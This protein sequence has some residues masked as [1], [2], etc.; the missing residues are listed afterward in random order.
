MI[1]V[2]VGDDYGINLEN[3]S[4]KEEPWKRIALSSVYYRYAIGFL[5]PQL[6]I[7]DRR[8]GSTLYGARSLNIGLRCPLERSQEKIV[9][10]GAA[11]VHLSK[12]SYRPA[13][14]F[15]KWRPMDSSSINSSGYRIAKSGFQV[16]T[17]ASTTGISPPS[18]TPSIRTNVRHGFRSGAICP[19]SSLSD[20]FNPS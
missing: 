20:R 9:C 19:A 11:N 1:R 8:L 5:R 12:Q 17:I 6:R 3:A 13:V 14:V 16:C 10:V 4:I 15:I 2:C 18:E 7:H